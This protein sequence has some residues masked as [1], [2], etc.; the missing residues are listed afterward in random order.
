MDQRPHTR[1]VGL[2][3]GADILLQRRHLKDRR[4]PEA[5]RQ[6]LQQRRDPLAAQPLGDRLLRIGIILGEEAGEVARQIGIGLRAGLKL[7]EQL[8]LASAQRLRRQS[9][10]R[11]TRVEGRLVSRAG[12]AGNVLAVHP[13]QLL[14]VEARRRGLALLKR[15]GLRHLLA[16]H[17]LAVVARRPAQQRQIVEERLRQIPLLAEFAHEG[18]PVALRIGLTR[19]VDDHRQMRI[20]RH[21]RPQRT[22]KH[23][24]LERILDMVVAAD[25]VRHPLRDVVEHVRQMEDRGTVRA[26]DDKVL[27]VLRLL[28][29]V[30]L[31]QVVI[32]DYALL[33]HP[34]DD[35]L[36]LAALVFAV[37]QAPG[38]EILGHRQMVLPLRGLIKNLLVPVQPQPL[39][40]VDQRLNRLRRRTLQI[41]ILH[42]QQKLSPRVTGIEPIENRGTDIADVHLPRRRRGKTDPDLIS[43]D[44]PLI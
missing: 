31:H 4:R 23:D 30:P 36:A 16:R 26:H 3:E 7:I 43:H 18:R 39:H 29:D 41:G 24:V 5:V 13:R 10:R 14:H 44:L 28:L 19:M 38:H 20:L 40:A 2:A 25:D 34:E 8:L 11:Q 32:G 22:E 12:L 37:G 1:P 17:D 35:A 27:R 15:K 21:R 33:R 42:A 9:R 6:R